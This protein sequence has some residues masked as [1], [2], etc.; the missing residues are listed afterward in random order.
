MCLIVM[1]INALTAGYKNSVV[2]TIEKRFEFSSGVSGVLSGCL[3][4]GSLITTLLVSYFCSKSHIPRAIAISS[5][6]CAVGSFLYALPHLLTESYSID[7][8]GVNQT[9]DDLLC[10]VTEDFEMKFSPLRQQSHISLLQEKFK[11]N[12]ECLLK[13]HNYGIFAIL[14]IANFL[15]GSSSAP[16]YTLGTTYIDNHVTKDNSSIYLGT[17]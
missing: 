6:L 10:H 5:I 11:I 8:K 4:V 7:N 15:I 3:E 1:L 9:T 16:L 12:P 13:L 2:T 17:Y 14:I